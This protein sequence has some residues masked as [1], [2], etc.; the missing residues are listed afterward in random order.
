MELKIDLRSYEWWY[1]AV[2][3]IAIIVGLT[4]VKES[5]YLV[6]AISVIQF[7]HF[8]VS[9]GFSSVPTQVRLVYAIFTIIGLLDPTHIFYWVLLVGTIMVVLFDR[10]MII[11]IL[12]LMP[13]NRDKS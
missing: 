8:A 11:K 12:M 6:V 3:L 2:T 10:C 9:Q 13:W 5:F 1:W 4:G 7:M